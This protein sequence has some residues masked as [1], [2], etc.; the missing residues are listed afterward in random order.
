MNQEAIEVFDARAAELV[1]LDDDF[2]LNFEFDDQDEKPVKKSRIVPGALI[3]TSAA[4]MEEWA[5]TRLRP[6]TRVLIPPPLPLA[7]DAKSASSDACSALETALTGKCI[8][9]LAATRDSKAYETVCSYDNLQAVKSLDFAGM[10]LDFG[11]NCIAAAM[12][13]PFASY[14]VAGY[15]LA[16]FL[17]DRVS[18]IR[19]S[20]A[21]IG[22]WASGFAGLAWPDDCWLN[23]IPDG[24]V[25]R[26][27]GP[28]EFSP[29]TE[30]KLP[31]V[32]PR[33]I[34]VTGTRYLIEQPLLLNQMTPVTTTAT[35]ISAPFPT[36]PSSIDEE[37]RSSMSLLS[38]MTPEQ[39]QVELNKQKFVAQSSKLFALIERIS[40]SDMFRTVKPFMWGRADPCYLFNDKPYV[41]ED[42]AL[43]LAKRV[44]VRMV[45]S[46]SPHESG[47][48]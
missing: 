11:F 19:T 45:G 3:D 31:P 12:L 47:D 7:V 18:N 44:F 22:S 27:V 36:S 1:S 2:S 24:P 26:R 20:I 23:G 10:S 4:R 41:I 33:D 17:P 13:S 14:R 5:K 39:R 43:K 16:R 15:L 38:A 21:L 30:R 37:R 25:Y 40:L 35:E 48:S 6:G 34:M 28:F 42:Q 9:S 46:L 8:S 29:L 32:P